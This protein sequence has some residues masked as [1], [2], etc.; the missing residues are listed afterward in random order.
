MSVYSRAFSSAHAHSV[1]AGAPAD[2]YFMP[3]EQVLELEEDFDEI[4]EAYSTGM[5]FIRGLR[6][7][8]ALEA[9]AAMACFG[10]WYVWHL[11][12]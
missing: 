11:V 7:A 9:V 4:Q 2:L 8:F 1:P 5:G 12:R 3:V 10:V 6:A